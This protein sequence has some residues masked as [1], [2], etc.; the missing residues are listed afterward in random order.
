M[1]YHAGADLKLV[2]AG[3]AQEKILLFAQDSDGTVIPKCWE[4]TSATEQAGPELSVSF[5]GR[6]FNAQS[7]TQKIGNSRLE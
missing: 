6:D 1:A 7:V 4:M 2:G 3:Y 5:N